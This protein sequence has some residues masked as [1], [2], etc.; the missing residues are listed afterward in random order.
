[1]TIWNEF[2]QHTALGILFFILGFSAGLG[3]Y[4]YLA[5]FF[6]TEVVVKGSYLPRA[7]IEKQFVSIEKYTIISNEYK[8]FREEVA[9]G[10]VSETVHSYVI[11]NLEY[12]K[13]EFKRLRNK[14]D[15]LDNS[16]TK[17]TLQICIQN[18]KNINSLVQLQQ[19]VEGL[20]GSLVSKFNSSYEKSEYQ[21]AS[22]LLKSDQQRIYSQQLN[23]QLIKL[24][25]TRT[26]C[27]K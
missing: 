13:L 20:I 25:E 2:K 7:D 23:L 21:I 27:I 19:D 22:D 17:I 8:D 14:Y 1:M 15:V 16:Q 9:K 11:E 18:S 4:K 5:D 6:N 10:Y 12:Y 24:Y 26:K 3:A